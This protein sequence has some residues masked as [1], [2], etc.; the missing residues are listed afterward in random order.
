[1]LLTLAKS[2]TGFG[3]NAPWAAPLK[4][5]RAELK[6]VLLCYSQ[7]LAPVHCLSDTQGTLASLGPAKDLMSS[8]IFY[9]WSTFRTTAGLKNEDAASRAR[10]WADTVLISSSSH[11]GIGFF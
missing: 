5:E 9:R 3:R 6:D 2:L 8:F 11:Q 10:V 4:S 7:P 1:M